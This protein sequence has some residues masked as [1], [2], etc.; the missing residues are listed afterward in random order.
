M[1]LVPFIAP[2]GTPTNEDGVTG[3]GGASIHH[4]SGFVERDAKNAAY[5]EEVYLSISRSCVPGTRR[6]NLDL[7]FRHAGALI[8][9]DQRDIVWSAGTNQLGIYTVHVL[10]CRG[11]RIVGWHPSQLLPPT[12]RRHL[13]HSV[14][15][16]DAPSVPPTLGP[17]KLGRGLTPP[18]VEGHDRRRRIPGFLG[19]LGMCKIENDIALYLR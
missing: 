4:C 2:V 15:A 18:I 8:Q 3:G 10:K 13:R 6:M 9:R 19:V 12:L 16:S 7:K 5:S 17:I 11:H 14:G 1:L